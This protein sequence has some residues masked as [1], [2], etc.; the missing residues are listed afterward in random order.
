MWTRRKTGYGVDESQTFHADM[1]LRVEA[2][3]PTENNKILGDAQLH[4]LRNFGI[5][6]RND[7]PESRGGCYE[8][9]VRASVVVVAKTAVRT[10]RSVRKI[11]SVYGEINV[12]AVC[13]FPVSFLSVYSAADAA[14]AYRNVGTA[15]G[16]GKRYWSHKILTYNFVLILPGAL[17]LCYR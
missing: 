16:S 6:F 5:L 3:T 1:W 10:R 2:S 11:L 7:T 13:L 8:T 12:D 4:C 15:V 9:Y 17:F 14:T